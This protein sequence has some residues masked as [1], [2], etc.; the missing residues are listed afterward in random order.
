MSPPTR[1]AG[2]RHERL[3]GLPTCLGAAFPGQRFAG[4]LGGGRPRKFGQTQT[5][6]EY[7]RENL[8]LS[9]SMEEV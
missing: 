6:S 8:R 2:Q 4:C 7:E 5:E 1:R 3:R 9:A